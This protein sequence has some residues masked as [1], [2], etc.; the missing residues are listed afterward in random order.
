MNSAE[1]GRAGEEAAAAYLR[2]AGYEIRALNWRHGRY[3]LD[4]VASKDAMLHIVEV[5]TRRRGSLTTPEEAITPQKFRALR[6]A[7][8]YYAATT[9]EE[10]EVQFDLAAVE[11]EPDGTARVRLVEQAM[12]CHW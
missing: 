6:R 10:L 9:G 12:E 3:E 11:M 4:I 8:A 1:T 2:E 5:K 7:A